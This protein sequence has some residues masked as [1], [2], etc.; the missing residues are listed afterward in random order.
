MVVALPAEG[1]RVLL[2]EWVLSVD[3]PNGG[4]GAAGSPQRPQQHCHHIGV[5]VA[6]CLVERRP[7]RQHR[8]G[9]APKAPPPAA[10]GLCLGLRP[11][12]PSM[13]ISQS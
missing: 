13:I 10:P 1:A 6:R 3:D 11:S 4:G 7:R 2:V 12:Y 9:G 5:P 8:G